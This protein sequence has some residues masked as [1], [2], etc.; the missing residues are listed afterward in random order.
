MAPAVVMWLA[1]V[2]ATLALKHERHIKIEL[3]LRLLPT[4]GQT[5]AQVATNLFAMGVCGVLGYAAVPFLVNEIQLFGVW[6]WLAV[7]LPFFFGVAFLRFALN[8]MACLG[9]MEE[10]P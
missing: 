7:C 3:A 10:A 8:L 5:A 9:L 4:K 6:G 2:G 1:L